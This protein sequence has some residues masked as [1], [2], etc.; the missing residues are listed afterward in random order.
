MANY[1]NMVDKNLLSVFLDEIKTK[2]PTSVNNNKP[3]SKGN[4]TLPNFI[5][6]S[7][8][9]NGSNGLVPA[10]KMGEQNKVL[11]ADGSWQAVVKTV[12]GNAPDS[13][14][15]IDVEEYT[16]P[17]SGVTAGTYRQVTV[18]KQGHVTKGENPIL[19]I[20]SGGTGATTAVDAVKAL[21][22]SA[23]V[24][25]GSTPIYYSN[26]KLVAGNYTF[27]L[28][29]NTSDTRIPVFSSGAIDYVLKSEIATAWT[30]GGIV[31]ELLGENGY[32]KFANGL[33]I[34]W[35]K[36]SEISFGKNNYATPKLINNTT[37]SLPISMDTLLS[38]WVT[39]EIIG[40]KAAAAASGCIAG[41]SGGTITLSHST[42]TDSGNGSALIPL[43][44]VVGK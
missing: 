27:R 37:A 3:D 20:S 6:S 16:H 34:Q 28:N 36:A 38:G 25:S 30:G 35:G 39:Y 7:S 33:I 15:N 41:H 18:D 11:C 1:P 12:N 29:H 32:V 19:A 17:D 31:N 40:G 2:F 42:M 24:G 13:T 21:L 43:Y 5:G 14:G 9:N 4:I 8:N 22:G 44:L 23:A 10:P 26:G